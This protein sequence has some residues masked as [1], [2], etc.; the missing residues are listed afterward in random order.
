MNKKSNY[1]FTEKELEEI[2]NI[3]AQKS[4]DEAQRKLGFN[5]DQFLSL[6]KINTKLDKAIKKGQEIRHKLQNHQLYKELDRFSSF[7]EEELEKIKQI[8]LQRAGIKSIQLEYKISKRTLEHLRQRLPKI[9]KAINEGVSLRKQKNETIEENIKKDTEL[10]VK[11]KSKPVKVRKGHLDYQLELKIRQN[12]VYESPD[13][14]L[15]KYKKL[16]EE[17]KLQETKKRLENGEFRDI[18]SV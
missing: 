16:V 8:A 10:K 12:N 15:K 11:N 2:T 4:I 13:T 6:R 3:V 7:S 5:G 1:K 14:A 9:A 17:R 18:I